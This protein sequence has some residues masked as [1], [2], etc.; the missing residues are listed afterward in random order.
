MKKFIALLSIII[1]SSVLIL[2]CGSNKTVSNLEKDTKI[3]NSKEEIDKDNSNYIDENNK[4]ENNINSNDDKENAKEK[5]DCK[6]E[7]KDCLPKDKKTK[8]TIVIDP[9]HSSKTSKETEIECPGSN[10]R[11]LK[12]TLGATGIESNIPEYIITHDIA[13]D[14]KEV[15]ISQGYN[16]ILTKD[17]PE[18]ELSNI[19]RTTIGNEANANLV[20][21]IHCDSVDSPKACGASILVPAPKGNV[22]DEIADISYAYGEKIINSYTN[23]T[24]FKNRGVVTR[25]DLTGF[26]WSK[27]PI[28]LIELGFLSNPKEDAY[29]SNKDNYKN[30]SL[31]IALGINNCFGK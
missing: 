10:K 13:K 16:V 15:L 9:G 30:I 18:K 8:I 2:G 12:D 28:V 19:E 20:I 3:N 23:Y 26:N 6:E 27:V 1:F 29:L 4:E 21:R 22:T 11:K 5:D 14:L 7:S 24:G 31:G 25:D 17:S